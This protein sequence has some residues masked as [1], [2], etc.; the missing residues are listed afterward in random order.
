MRIFLVNLAQKKDRLANADR[1]LKARGIAYERFP[2]VYGKALSVAERRASVAG[3]HSWCA[4]GRRLLDGEIGCALSHCGIY[5]RM[6]D[7]RI[8]YALV[9]EDDIAIVGDLAGALLDVESFCNP[10]RPQIILLTH[11]TKGAPDVGISRITYEMFTEGYV[12]TL[13]AARA[14]CRANYPVVTVADSWGRWRRRGIIEL[15][16]CYPPALSQDWQRFTESDINVGLK[17]VAGY[18]PLRWMLHKTMR[19]FGRALDEVM[20]LI[21]RR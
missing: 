10:E 9:L 6:V 21:V 8:P 20:Y 14:L 5:R 7:E 2:A 16:K 15:Y 19:V 11:H 18:S 13:A 12:V 1:Q 3:F 17:G 4:M